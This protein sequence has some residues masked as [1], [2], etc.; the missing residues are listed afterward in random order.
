MSVA[1]ISHVAHRLSLPEWIE[2]DFW[3]GELENFDLVVSPDLQNVAQLLEA[4]PLAV[5][6]AALLKPDQYFPRA[7]SF[8]PVMPADKIQKQ[9][10]GSF[11]TI[12]L[13]TSLNFVQQAVTYFGADNLKLSNT[14]I[15]DFGIGWGRL[16]R[17]WLKYV[18]PSQLH[19]CDAWDMSLDLAKACML[20]NMLVKSDSLLAELPYPLGSFD[21]IYAFSIFTHLDESAFKGCLKGIGNMLKPNGRA[22]F[23]VRPRRFWL[24]TSANVANYDS[25]QKGIIFQ[26]ESNDPHFGNTTV[27]LQWVKDVVLDAGLTFSGIEWSP[28]DALQI[29]VKVSK[30]AAG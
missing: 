6:G 8:L 25:D 14:K 11:G 18:P 12:L 15:L 4:V 30:P 10:T 27:D 1:D 3:K 26:H 5:W 24:H 2:L 28:S 29:L 17:L 22:I 9:W 13:E 23:T 20:Q 21:Y 19:G 16:A 7:S